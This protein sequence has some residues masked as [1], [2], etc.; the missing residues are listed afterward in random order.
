MS[1]NYG[2]DSMKREFLLTKNKALNT[3]TTTTKRQKG[4]GGPSPV[5]GILFL[6]KLMLI[7]QS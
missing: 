4:L 5:M 2:K 6:C 7:V 1:L 3:K